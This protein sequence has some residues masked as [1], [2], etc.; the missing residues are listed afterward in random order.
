MASGN[1]GQGDELKMNLLYLDIVLIL[2]TSAEDDDTLLSQRDSELFQPAQPTQHRYLCLTPTTVQVHAQ[3]VEVTG[4]SVDE[5]QKCLLAHIHAAQLPTARKFDVPAVQ[6]LVQRI[7]GLGR[8][9]GAQRAALRLGH[10]VPGEHLVV[11]VCRVHFWHGGTVHQALKLRDQQRFFVPEFVAQD[12][13]HL[14]GGLKMTSRPS[15][16]T[17]RHFAVLAT[18]RMRLEDSSDV[19]VGI[20]MHSIRGG[21]V[22]GGGGYG[23]GPSGPPQTPDYDIPCSQPGQVCVGIGQCQG[24]YV[25]PGANGIRQGQCSSASQTCCLQQQP[26][27]PQQPAYSG[28]YAQPQPQPPPQIPRPQPQPTYQGGYNAPQPNYYQP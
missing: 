16:I 26:Q 24:G 17:S 15:T 12:D 25:A 5:G 9:L 2:E 13:D 3:A 28:G 14:E 4:A 19:K 11:P 7:N 21:Q 1:N 6:V 23:A 18:S 10:G 20:S 8:G 22:G 27:Q